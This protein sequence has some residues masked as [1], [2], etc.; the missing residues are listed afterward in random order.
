MGGRLAGPLTRSVKLVEN[1]V[2]RCKAISIDFIRKPGN[3]AVAGL[4]FVIG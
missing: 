4:F 3:Y 2:S 1:E